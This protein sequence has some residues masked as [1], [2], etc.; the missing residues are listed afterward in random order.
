[1]AKQLSKADKWMIAMSELSGRF[2][3]AL[4]EYY[5]GARLADAKSGKTLGTN[6]VY[7]C[8]LYTAHRPRI[9]KHKDNGA[10][11]Q[12]AR[13]VPGFVDGLT[14]LSNVFGVRLE[15]RAA[16]MMLVDA[17][18]ME[19]LGRLQETAEGYTVAELQPA[20]NS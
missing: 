12:V 16:P 18:T 20:L 10:S 19:P 5:D 7:V 14:Q 1:M 13:D 6:L 11:S 2:G 4:V 17:E 8:C 9:S 15:L 3:V